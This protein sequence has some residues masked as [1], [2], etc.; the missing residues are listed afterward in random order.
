[1]SVQQLL[2]SLDKSMNALC[3]CQGVEVD[4]GQLRNA[5]TF[6]GFRSIASQV[7]ESS[8]QEKI[9]HSLLCLLLP[10]MITMCF[11][12]R[13]SSCDSTISLIITDSSATSVDRSRRKS[14]D[15]NRLPHRRRLDR[16][17]TP[18]RL[19]MQSTMIIRNCM[20][21]PRHSITSPVDSIILV[22]VGCSSVVENERCFLLG[23]RSTRVPATVRDISA[24][25]FVGGV[26]RYRRIR[27]SLWPFPLESV[28][29]LRQRLGRRT[30]DNNM[31]IIEFVVL[32]AY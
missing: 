20:Q 3:I 7:I 19:E 26:N 9:G 24:S 22:R 30:T 28:T 11:R 21:S 4:S 5:S 18:T 29:S 17:S 2:V 16:C 23:R 25:L 32:P 31:G 10:T 1:M 27:R 15:T 8:F 13:A 14:N 12:R 6:E